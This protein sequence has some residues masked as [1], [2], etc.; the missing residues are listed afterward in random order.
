MAYKDLRA[1][2]QRLQDE[3]QLLN[4]DE[5]VN[6]EPDLGAAGRA[7]NYLGDQAPALHF[8]KIRSY[9]NAQ[10]AMNI[11]GSWANHALMLNIPKT[12]AVKEQ[13]FEFV[14]RWNTY[15]MEVEYVQDAPFYEHEI[16]SNINLYDTLPLFRLNMYD[17]GCYID[18]ACTVTRDPNHPDDFDLQNV[19]IYRI[20]VKGKDH[21]GIQVLPFHDAAA[22]LYAAEERGENLPIAITIGNEPVITTIA[23]SPLL[24]NQ[25]E[26]KM[27]GAMQGE[28]YKVVKGKRTGLDLPWGA[29]IVLEGEMLEGERE[30]EGPFGE[31]T[32]A[33]SGIRRQPVIKINAIYHRTNPIY[34]HVYIGIPWTEIDYLIGIN[35][36]VAIYTQ[37]KDAYPEVEA[38]NATYLNGLVAIVSTRTAGRVGGFAKAV[39]LRTIT[40]THGIG[41]CKI[42]IVVDDDI[43]PFDLKQVM[44]ALSTRF[45]PN[46][47]LVVVP[48][49]SIISLD[50][51]SDPPGM[52]HKL[53]LDATI[54]QPPDIR[55]EKTLLIDP[56]PTTAHWHQKILNDV[57]KQKG[58][59][60]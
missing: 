23:G 45:T 41:Y 56:P 17:A 58:G 29:E 57:K 3:G 5:E 13:F 44:W 21:L 2:M 19:G 34:E 26:Y 47:D 14:R 59:K 46:K 39:G 27:A 53:I 50:P 16:T 4:I 20:Q 15:P 48:T 25:S 24:Y 31:F 38:V 1:F 51:S 22:H 55:G 52:S 12:T 37:L 7:V 60:T 42:V 49:A 33:Y 30:I 35:T 40:T 43:D 18:K 8:K 36:C 10:I 11:L 32:G 9:H 54:P 6:L 28:P